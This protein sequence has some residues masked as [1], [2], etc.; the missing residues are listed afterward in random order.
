[1]PTTLAV[2]IRSLR[3]KHKLTQHQ[4][5][6]RA[7]VRQATISDWEAGKVHTMDYAT[8]SRVCDALGVSVQDV[9]LLP[10]R[11]SKRATD[12]WE[13]AADLAPP[14][15]AEEALALYER[16]ALQWSKVLTALAKHD[17]D[18]SGWG[19]LPAALR[20]RTTRQQEQRELEE[21]ERSGVEGYVEQVLRDVALTRDAI[22]SKDASNAVFFALRAGHS[23]GA[24]RA[25][26]SKYER[27]KRR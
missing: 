17:T 1:M 10:N 26:M 13:A 2:R 19:A 20:R 27:P 8:L 24:A 14:E 7:G 15:T 22:K 23:H 16:H 3:K 6:E 4:L 11:T 12:Q 25:L 5:A 18:D 9:M 21:A